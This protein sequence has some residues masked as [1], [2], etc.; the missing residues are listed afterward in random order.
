M[1]FSV[2][3]NHFIFIQAFDLISLKTSKGFHTAGK[4][5]TERLR[6]WGWRV[7][8]SDARADGQTRYVLTFALAPAP[9]GAIGHGCRVRAR[10]QD[11][12]FVAGAAWLRGGAG[13]RGGA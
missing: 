11:Q 7:H 9:L 1:H 12:Q 6:D 13:G 5:W 3:V 8:I 2:L 4:P 10:I